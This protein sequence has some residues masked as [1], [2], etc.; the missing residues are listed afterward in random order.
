MGKNNLKLTKNS[1][2]FYFCYSM[3]SD[4]EREDRRADAAG[5]NKRSQRKSSPEPESV[6]ANAAFLYCENWVAHLI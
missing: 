3:S 2:T 1:L 6:L 4:D 5:N